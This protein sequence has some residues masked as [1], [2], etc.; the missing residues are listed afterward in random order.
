MTW[1]DIST[2]AVT[3]PLLAANPGEDHAPSKLVGISTTSVE[4]ATFCSL[5]VKSRAR[6]AASFKYSERNMNAFSSKSF[7]CSVKRHFATGEDKPKT[8]Y[9]FSSPVCPLPI[10]LDAKTLFC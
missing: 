1:D 5:I 8:L 10:T 4:W 7:K 9:S 2:I 6:D 3:T